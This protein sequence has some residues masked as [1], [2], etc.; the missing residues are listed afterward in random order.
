MGWQG[1]AEGATGLDP[2]AF[3]DHNLSMHRNG[4]SRKAAKRYTVHDGHL[5]LTIKEAEKGWLT[6]TSPLDPGLVTQ[7]RSLTEAFAMA[8][9]ALRVL[10]AAD[11]S[12][13]ASLKSRRRPRA[14]GAR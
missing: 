9:A 5:I 3:E 4:S 12:A 14:S 11:S 6:V 8:K 13:R 2:P 10:R 7:A 1:E